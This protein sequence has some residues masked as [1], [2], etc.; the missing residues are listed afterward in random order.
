MSLRGFGLCAVLAA[1]ALISARE[2]FLTTKVAAAPNA[3]AT[4]AMHMSARLRR[5]VAAAFVEGR[6][7]AVANRR[8]GS[9]S[10]VDVSSGA[11]L[12]ESAV[13]RELSGLQALPGGDLLTVD[14]QSDAL[15]VVRRDDSQLGR[16]AVTNRVATSRSPESV[17]ATAD[18]ATI[19]VSCLW[20]RRLDL[21]ARKALRS[22][23]GVG[24][25]SL[26]AAGTVELPFSPRLLLWLPGDERLLVADAFG[27]EL[28][29]VDPK[30]VRIAARHS[31]TAHNLR[32]LALSPDG[33]HVFASHQVLD[34]NSTIDWRSVHS[35][36]LMANGVRKLP[37]A[38][39][40]DPQSRLDDVSETIDVGMTGHGAGDP[41]AL[42]ALPDGGLLVCSAGAGEAV[43]LNRFLVVENRF[44][45]GRRPTAI[46]P[47]R[48]ASEAI[49][50]DTFDDSLFVVDLEAATVPRSIP[51]GPQPELTA[52]E[53]GELAFHDARLSHD[54]WMSCH[55]CHPDGHTH[56][57][58]SD[59]L[60]DRSTGAPKRTLTLRG[61]I[62]THLWAWTGEE[63]DLAAQVRKSFDSSLLSDGIDGATVNDVLAYIETL[64]PLPASH[65]ATGSKE[66]AERIER[67]RRVFL[68][69]ACHTCHVPP[70]TYTSSES[71][72]VGL[73]DENGVRKFNP[74]S[75]RGVGYGSRYFHDG[76]AK[77]LEDVF[78]RHAHPGDTSLTDAELADLVRFLRSL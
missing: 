33:R 32:G 22:G 5:P 4:D 45:V 77:S 39:L 35:G 60:G 62:H 63:D 21:F 15:L 74:P 24:A 31:L 17:A 67:G 42:L 64:P 44:A 75:L 30:G 52:A 47:G 20:S 48:D 73:D 23:D 49:V 53:R 8:S 25:S 14:P 50:L 66:D 12:G 26:A 57:L 11:I 78:R 58:L 46:L 40:L 16:V 54:S 10:L 69:N 36:R 2:R 59:T 61:V 76:R 71:F 43:G 13:A 65:P 27:G 7:L 70:L 34:E 68:D 19:A 56:G 41:S 3:A 38:A 72:D 1:I 9:V 28:A 6:L 18:G 29:V 55:S 51:L 37:V